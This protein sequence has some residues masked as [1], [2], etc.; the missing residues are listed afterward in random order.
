MKDTG[1]V[2]FSAYWLQQ[3]LCTTLGFLG[4]PSDPSCSCNMCLGKTAATPSSVVAE[5]MQQGTM[6]VEDAAGTTDLAWEPEVEENEQ[7]E[8]M[9]DL[10]DQELQ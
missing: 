2:F 3:I 1:K 10:V 5:S 6:A 8:A 9:L 7:A 4:T